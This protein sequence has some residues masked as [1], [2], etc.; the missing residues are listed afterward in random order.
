MAT[1]LIIDD[2]PTNRDVLRTVLGYKSHRVLEACDGQEG[3]KVARAERPDLVITDILMPRMDGYEM[4]HNLRADPA[5]AA[6]RVIFYT[7]AFLRSE[8]LK[9]AQACGVSHL[10]VKPS[11]PQEILNTVAAVLSDGAMPAAPESNGTFDREH[12]RLMTDK[13]AQKVQELEDSNCGLIEEAAQRKRADDALRL[14][15]SRLRAVLDAVLDS[16]V[17]LDC[18]GNVIDV[19][20]AT[21]LIFG[22]RREAI[23]GRPLAEFLVAASSSEQKGQEPALLISSNQPAL[24]GRRFETT[25]VT[26]SSALLSIEITVTR[27]AGEEPPMYTACLRDL[28]EERARQE[29]RRHSEELE[30]Q[31]CFIQAAS[32]LKS[33]FLANMSHELRTPL[34]AIIGFSELMHDGRV[35]PISDQ[36]KDFLE[37][38]LTSGRHL[39]LLINDVLDLSK[40]EAGKMEF[41]PEPVDLE[42]I[43]N[44]VCASL[45][46][47]TAPKQIRVQTTTD[48]AL[49]D[50]VTDR[51]S[52]K[53]VLYNYLSNAIKFTGPCGK[54]DLRIVP[55][56]EK[57]FRI[58]IADSGIGI[59]AE[60]IGK[61]FVEFQQ[62]DG[63]ESKKYPGTG[64]GLALTKRMVESQG[65]RVGV[66]SEIGLGSTFFAV[67]P[68]NGETK[69]A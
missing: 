38:I 35:G 40:I 51:R 20:T 10:I 66:K 14:S 7:A 24:L 50:I 54:I 26:A 65:G 9:L 59:A 2:R 49:T 3:L 32:R 33:E 25:A 6:T 22:Y 39:L 64:L 15:E 61:L 44:E 52:L 56:A 23:I 12:L 19:N 60:N 68:R 34:N 36:H 4:V 67:L 27:I 29:M 47:L 41:N 1:I 37:D 17:T 53:Q 18:N 46:G 45:N 5:I 69:N 8:A 11:D 16:I 30:A 55:E 57:T 58:E 13:L 21:E 42:A 62:I 63:K 31:N 28:T 48:P 43:A